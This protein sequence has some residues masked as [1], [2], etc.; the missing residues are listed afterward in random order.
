M[1]VYIIIAITFERKKLRTL[2]NDLLMYYTKATKIYPILYRVCWSYWEYC[3]QSTAYQTSHSKRWGV[4]AVQHWQQ[5]PTTQ[6]EGLNKM[7]L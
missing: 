6:H 7:E 3:S 2:S 1:H 5:E 4:K